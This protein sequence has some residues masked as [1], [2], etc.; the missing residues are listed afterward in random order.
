M[1][2][3]DFPRGY[4]IEHLGFKGKTIGG[5]QVSEKHCNFIVNKDNAK[6][7]DIVMLISVIKQKVRSKV[8]IQLHEEVQMVGF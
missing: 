8:G 3:G 6:A 5:A 2:L 1:K 4:I 7:T